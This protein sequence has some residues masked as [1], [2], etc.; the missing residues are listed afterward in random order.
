MIFKEQFYIGYRDV[1]ANYKIKNSSILNIFQDIAGM[2]S[3]EATKKHKNLQSTWV[4]TGYKVNIIKNPKYGEKLNVDTWATEI[5]NIAS[6]REFEIRNKQGELVITGISNWV[7]LNLETKKFEKVSQ[8][9]ADAYGLEPDK[10]NYDEPKL[11]KINE[12]EEYKYEKEFTVNWN[13]I[14]VNQHMSN[15][16]YLDIVDM[17]LSDEDRKQEFSSFEVSYKKEIKYKDKVKCFYAEEEDSKIITIKS[18]DLSVVHAI[19]K[20]NK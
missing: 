1:D 20:L 7:H 17:M 9:L 5:K 11:K 8:E 10:T 3:N 16:Y 14:D 19:V 12:P 6:S 15:I 13:W 2:H 18:E 4:L